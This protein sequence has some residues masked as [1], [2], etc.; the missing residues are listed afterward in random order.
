MHSQPMKQ[1]KNI[2]GHASMFVA[3]ACWGLMSPMGKDAM[4]HGISGLS[5]VTFRAVGAAICFLQPCWPLC[6]TSAALPSDC[7]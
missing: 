7:R 4:A 2:W 3:C 5:M 1:D 6:S